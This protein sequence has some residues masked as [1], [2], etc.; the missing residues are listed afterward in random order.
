MVHQVEVYTIR[1]DNLS[2]VPEIQVV[3]GENCPPQNVV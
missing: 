3:A 2:L 1:H